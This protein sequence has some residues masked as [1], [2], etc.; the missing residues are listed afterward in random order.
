MTSGPGKPQ[1]LAGGQIHSYEIDLAQ[2]LYLEATFEQRGT[3]LTVD[4][5]APGPGR[6]YRVDSPNRDQGPEDVHLVARFPGRY[7][8]EITTGDG[9]LPGTYIP[10]LRAVRAPTKTDRSQAA[11]DQAFYEAQEIDTKPERF[12]EAIAKYETSI[13]LFEEAGDRF[14]HAYAH[15]RLARVHTRRSGYREALDLFARAEGLFRDTGSPHLL[16][17]AINEQGVCAEKLGDFERASASYRQAA[18]LSRDTG[19]LR[20][21]AA[22][23]HNLGNLLQLQGRPWEALGS[24]REARALWKRQDGAEAR[25]READTL[26]G[27]GWV[28]QSTGDWQ[29]ALDAH[30]RALL[31]RNRLGDPR[32]R[33]SSLTQIGSVWLALEPRRALPYLEKAR[34]LQ[35]DL[36]GAAG[37]AATLNGLGIAYRGLGLYGQ[38]QSAYWK[39]LEL[40]TTPADPGGQS[41]TWTNLGLISL[42]LNQPGEALRRFENGLRLARRTRNPMAESRALLGLAIAESQRGNNSLA[43]S[44]AEESLKIVESLRSAITRADLQT[45]WL[46]SN[47]SAYGLL[48]RILMEQHRQQ[49]G[50]GYDLEAL[51]RSEQSR[52]RVL[53][54]ALRESRE[55]Q[56]ASPGLLAQRRAL[57]DE[58]GRMDAL[59][60]QPSAAPAEAAA[61]E[62]SLA[63]L[64]DR[65][66]E[67]EASIRIRNQRSHHGQAPPPATPG[68]VLEQRQ[69]LLGPDSLFLEYHLGS[70]KGYLWALSAEGGQSFE[71]PGR[72]TLEPLLRATYEELAGASAPIDPKTSRGLELSRVLLGPLAS[73][74]RGKR[75]LIAADGLQQSI[76][77]AALPSPLGNHQP[78]LVENEIFSVPSLAVLAELR[79]RAAR[80]EPPARTLAIVADPVFDASDE[81]LA[82][83]AAAQ[84]RDENQEEFLPRLARSREEAKAIASLLPPGQA[85]LALDFDAN[86]DLIADGHLSDFRI[87]HLATHGLQRIDDPELSALV[88]SR[89]D[90]QGNPRDGHLRVSDVRS[91]HLQADLVVLSA[92]ETALGRQ[93]PGEGLVGLPQ[94]F[95]TAGAQRVLVSLWQVEDES[96][97]ALMTH[98]YRRLLVD[99]LPPGKAL[100]EAQLAIRAQPRWRAP[101]YWAGFVL[102]GDWR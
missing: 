34:A 6:L 53:L 76:P 42:N 25:A 62:Q 94:A 47:E 74:L 80:R 85:L 41:I 92:C 69:A 4:V 36:P 48:I 22:S 20:E 58:V 19:D 1:Q 98:F 70:P 60:R 89:F 30:G 14:H 90:S 10:I 100:R 7:R 24:F 49:P 84:A 11:A 54:D 91:L 96:T 32:G 27:I 43:R 37:K 21:Q 64:L 31:L 97:A 33:S 81:R 65:L 88:L 101:R 12:W 5:F 51:G 56:Q 78:L 59:R 3:D 2:D 87:L 55:L 77:F 61:A 66:S 86:R 18:E 79:S 13:R 44:R 26:T 82:K 28:Y 83:T 67:I 102:Q 57:L 73:R 38:A 8:F 45:F 40:Y 9:A 99:R 15:F 52:A 17:L 72:E 29:R 71:L 39:A 46:A 23:L 93:T 75:L 95:L 16:T 50:G 35:Q 63:E 68:P